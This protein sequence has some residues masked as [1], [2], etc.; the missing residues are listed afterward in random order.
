M[1]ALCLVHV[2]HKNKAQEI[3]SFMLEVV[4]EICPSYLVTN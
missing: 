3:Y 4:T 2:T 1:T